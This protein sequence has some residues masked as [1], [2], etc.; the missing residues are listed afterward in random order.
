MLI[1]SSCSSPTIR[2]AITPPQSRSNAKSKYSITPHLPHRLPSFQ[3][4]LSCHFDSS[5]SNS[6]TVTLT[7]TTVSTFS[8]LTCSRFLFATPDRY[9]F[10]SYR[11]TTLGSIGFRAGFPDDISDFSAYLFDDVYCPLLHRQMLVT[12][13]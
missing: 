1:H 4:L 9:V 5:P 13:I 7:L 11:N 10:T 2:N 8:T 6:I 3:H 12:Y